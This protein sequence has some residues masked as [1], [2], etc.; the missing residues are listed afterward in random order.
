MTL[1]SA[2]PAVRVAPGVGPVLDHARFGAAPA[3]LAGDEVLSHA[4]LAR[5]VADRAATWGPARRLVLV[6]GANDLDSLVAYL[7]ALQH[8]H[9][10]LVVPDGRPAQ[11]D[12][13]LA[14]YDPDVVCTAGARD[15]VRR[16][17][18]AHDLHPD[19]ALLLSTSGTTGSPKLVR[20]SR[21]N[22]ASNAAAIADYLALTPADRAVTTLPLHYC[23]G[24]SVLHSH[25]A[26]GASVV[27]TDL[28]VVDACFWDLF[29]RAG[30]TGLAGVPHT[31]DLLAA[32]GFED[33]DLPT[34]RTVTQ[35]GGRLAPDDVRRW[36][37]SG[38]RRGWDLV[39]MYGATE[40]TARMA[41]LPPDLA[42]DHPDSIG[43]AI[44]GGH[45]RLDESV[46]DR[47]G[48]GELVYTG[49]NVMLGYAEEPAD[50]ALPRVTT[51]LRTGDLAR[52]R[53]GLFAVVGRRNRWGKVFGLRIDLD[54]VEAGLRADVDRHARVVATGRAVHAFVTSGRRSAAARALVADR[55]G[56]PAH[57]VRVSVV[58][59]VPLTG[60]GKPDYAALGE[61]ATQ[62]EQEPGTTAAPERRARTVRA[63]VVRVLARPDATDADSFVS[64]GGDSLSYV[65]LATRLADHFPRGLPTGWH[66]RSIG[67][68]QR[69]AADAAAPPDPDAPAIAGGTTAPRTD[70]P[71]RRTTYLDTSVALRALAIVFIV[72]SHVDLVALEGGAHLLLA[73]AGFNFARFQLSAPGGARTRLRHGLAGLA[74]LVVPAVLWVGGVALV[75]GS[76]DLTTVLF[77]REVVN[78][79]E[80]DDQ[81]QLWFLES[82]VWLTAAALALTTLPVLHRLERRTPF[83]FALGV[84]AVATVARVAEVGLRAGPTERYTTLVVAF[85]FALG[86]AGARAATTR[87]RLVVSG[88]ALLLV[89]GF[90]GEVHREV[91]VVGGF[92]LL[93]WRPHVPVSPLLARVA[94]VLAT[95][96]LFIYLTH[97]QVYPPLEDAGHQWLALVASITVGVAYAYVV[98]PVHQTVGRAV[99][100]SR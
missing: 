78:G 30:V 46:D 15:D 20:L 87:Q 51:E 19:L 16:P 43:V 52:E 37:R 94:G 85:F 14:A 3:V 5:R 36:S 18:S 57:A 22:V 61:L 100:G 27:L 75:L 47:P 76:Y 96:S 45:L 59:Q 68:L 9:V 44:P 7:A 33:R 35:A 66:V 63:D 53:D 34:L 28:S 73:L 6:E 4:D 58:P 64:L 91:I 82:L 12:A 95:A 23:Y 98:R 65:E 21:D 84:L 67:D 48:V 17:T 25:L 38:R 39:V 49:P 31:F 90:F 60:S 86:W 11:R 29:E 40:A 89:V 69:L 77:V 72:A 56:V 26:V 55:C 81:W 83:R 42:E 79:S 10:A 92:L 41:W 71:R 13:T 2:Q 32:S 54:A 8:G 24:L 74:Q 88:L 97:W 70:R 50:L 80:W 62:V 93:L 99:L 1:T